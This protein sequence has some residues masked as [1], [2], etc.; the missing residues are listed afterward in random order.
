MTNGQRRRPIVVFTEADDFETTG[1][2]LAII[3]GKGDGGRSMYGPGDE[4]PPGYER[5][6]V[7][8]F[9]DRITGPQA[10]NKLAVVAKGGDPQAM[11]THAALQIALRW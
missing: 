1:D 11:C 7:E 9:R 10:F 3:K 6:Q 2:L 5:L 4:L 8:I